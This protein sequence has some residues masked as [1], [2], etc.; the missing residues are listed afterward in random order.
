MLGTVKLARRAIKENVFNG[1]GIEFDGEGSWSFGNDVAR[2]VVISGVD[3]TSSSHTNNDKNNFLV[4]GKGP[5]DCINDS[6]G[7]GEKKFSINFSK[8]KTKLKVTC[9]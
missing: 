1:R 3:N 2:N 9:M 4:L 6:T 5:T 8:A 7:T